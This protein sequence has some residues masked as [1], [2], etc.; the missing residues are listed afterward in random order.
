MNEV[1]VHGLPGIKLRMP[2]YR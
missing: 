2:F 1:G